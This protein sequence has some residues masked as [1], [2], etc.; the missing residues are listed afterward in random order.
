MSGFA[1]G[2][3]VESSA[4]VELQVFNNTIID[5]LDTGL[6]IRGWEV[7]Q[8]YRVKNNLIHGSGGAD[9]GTR[10]PVAEMD[11]SHNLSSDDTAAGDRVVTNARL[12]FVDHD[13]GDY[14]LA[15]TDTD[16]IGAGVDLST[17]PY[18]AFDTDAAGRVRT[19]WDV[20]ALAHP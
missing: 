17:G 10:A 18:T 1:R 7:S 3:A 19:R 5:S 2:I 14:H 9:Y 16:A 11:F 15:D 13:N 20:G 8:R 4:D 12:S 6:W